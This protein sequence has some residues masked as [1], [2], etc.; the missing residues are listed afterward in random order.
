[1]NMSKQHEDI[2]DR[3]IEA[4]RRG[5]DPEKVLQEHPEEAPEVRPLLEMAVELENV[6]ADQPGDDPKMRGLLRAQTRAL[7][8][9]R[10]SRPKIT[11]FN[12]PVLVRA[13][14]LLLVVLALTWGT[15]TASAGAVPGE[16]LYPVKLMTERVKFLLTV[17]DDE[18]A[19][20]RLIFAEER[21]NEAVAKYNRGQG[22]DRKLLGEM[23]ETARRA[24]A[25][26]EEIPEA[27]RP[28]LVSRARHLSRHHHDMLERMKER[29]TPE[30]RRELEPY[31][32]K[33]RRRHQWMDSAPSAHEEEE[34]E[35]ESPER[36]RR[37]WNRWMRMC[38]R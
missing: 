38:P 30:Q 4:A 35:R 34:P 33:C 36:G 19:E 29:A 2:L 32:Q 28:L 37:R 6:S 18:K 27:K 5:D 23:L 31:I 7:A 20:L 11:L 25:E 12:R 22:I 21:L 14:A 9:Q 13:A 16:W 8:E 17:N 15:T 3:C 1:M 10:A 26:G 24:L